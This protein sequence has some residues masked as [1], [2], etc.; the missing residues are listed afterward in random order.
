MDDFRGAAVTGRTQFDAGKYSFF[1][2][3]GGGDDNGAEEL[4]GE[5]DDEQG[6]PLD[7]ALEASAGLDR[8]PMG[9]TFAGSS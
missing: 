4:G 9:G 7:G 2:F 8:R 5:L 1:D 3:G 6:D